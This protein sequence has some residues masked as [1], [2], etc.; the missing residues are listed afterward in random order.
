MMVVASEHGGIGDVAVIELEV[1]KLCVERQ[2]LIGEIVDNEREL[3]GLREK[4]GRGGS[5]LEVEKVGVFVA[6]VE[7]AELPGKD[8]S[9]GGLL[10]TVESG[11]AVEELDDRQP[12]AEVKSTWPRLKWVTLY[13][14]AGDWIAGV[15]DGA[16]VWYVRAGDRLPSGVQVVSVRL[17]PPGVS[18]GLNGERWLIPGPGG[19]S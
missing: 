8:G 6:P 2:E 17:S 1:L 19:G 16:K 4:S 5:A 18:V 7:L 12:I 13:G 10:A 11:S 15:S 3:A 14:S 9:R